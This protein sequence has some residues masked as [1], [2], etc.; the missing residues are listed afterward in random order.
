MARDDR[1]AVSYPSKGESFRV[2]PKTV[3]SFGGLI[4]L[5]WSEIFLIALFVGLT[6]ASLIARRLVDKRKT[7]EAYRAIAGRDVEK[8]AD[9]FTEN[10]EEL[11]RIIKD[12]G[13]SLPSKT[14]TELKAYTERL[15]TTA[16]KMKKYLV[17]EVRK[18]K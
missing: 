14:A 11:D 15:R 8:F 10:V 3:I 6:A 2:R 9:M 17:A 12:K 18:A 16:Q 5:G 1:G 13:G 7:H 4:D